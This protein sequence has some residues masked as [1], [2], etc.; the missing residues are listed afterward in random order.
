MNEPIHSPNKVDLPQA[1]ARVLGQILAA[2]NLELV[3]P[4]ISQVAEFYAETLLTIPG[5]AACYVCLGNVTASK[6]DMGVER[7]ED[8]L[9]FRKKPSEPASPASPSH[10]ASYQ[11]KLE[12]IPGFQLIRINSLQHDF[13]FFVIR[14]DNLELFNLYKPFIGNLANYVAISLEN[15]LQRDSLKKTHAELESRVAERTAALATSNLQ[16][17]EEINHRK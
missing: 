11:C 14:V 3:L 5:L 15:R 4:T 6:G 2:Q 16:L 12:R 7:C 13:G 9:A 17:Q 1:D 8:C 10:L